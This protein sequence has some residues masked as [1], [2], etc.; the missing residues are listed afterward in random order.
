[1]HEYPLVWSE[2]MC[3]QV[4]PDGSIIMQMKQIPAS[5]DWSE[6]T[7]ITTTAQV[8]LILNDVLSF[9]TPHNSFVHALHDTVQA[10]SRTRR[11]L[12]CLG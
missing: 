11:E 4:K 3:V 5:S 7:S 6:V 12:H 2:V 1:M 9:R 8:R 10:L